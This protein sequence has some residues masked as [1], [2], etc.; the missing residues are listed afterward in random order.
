M[1]AQEV[2]SPTQE[3]LDTNAARATEQL[4]NKLGSL[5][6]TLSTLEG[7]FP[8]ITARMTA[9]IDPAK[10]RTALSADVAQSIKAM[11]EAGTEGS[12]TAALSKVKELRSLVESG[13]SAEI[14]EA[15]E[16]MGKN[17]VGP[18]ARIF[19]GK[20]LGEIPA[21][22]ANIIEIL[23]AKCDLSNDGR[24]VADTHRLVLVPASIDGKPLTL[25]ALRELATE[26][27]NGK[28]P[29]FYEQDWYD[30]EAFANKPLEKSTWVL[31]YQTAAPK[32][33][34][35]TEAQQVALVEKLPNHRTAKILEHVGAMVFNDLENGERIYP[36]IYG[37]C[38]ER[39]ASGA[40]VYAGSFGARGLTVDDDD[41]GL[42]H[43]LLG[44]AVGRKLN[45]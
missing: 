32:S 29:S 10:L 37:R 39:S 2:P 25:K 38:E 3:R 17:M 45:T 30:N 13:G 41:G 43:D 19:E 24:R 31:E 20:D 27:G 12:L 8:G 5:T 44:R 14:A 18:D 9:I 21:L 34:N 36:S 4:T 42:R 11:M 7:V 1:P 28:D 33:E 16:L 22:P 35:K 15:K 6:A 40:R 23:N 26:A